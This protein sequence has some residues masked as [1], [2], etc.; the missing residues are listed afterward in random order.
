VPFLLHQ[1]LPKP[2]AATISH[3]N[4]D[5]YNALSALLR[6]GWVGQ[7]YLNPYFGDDP[8][9]TESAGVA[10]FMDRLIAPGAVTKTR[11]AAGQKLR[12][13]GRT[14][15]E[16]LWPPPGRAD[17]SLNDT[18]LVL[19]ITCDGRSLLVPGDLEE[20]GQAAL[21]AMGERVRSDVLILPH[22]GAWRD[23]LPAFVRAVA[24][25]IVLVSGSRRPAAPLSGGQAARE[26]YDKL[27]AEHRYYTTLQHGWIQVRFGRGG[28]SVRTMRR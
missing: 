2:S 4:S 24:P 9:R 8:H 26:F 20:V 1:R 11:L 3:A 10:R 22:H 15:V 27:P 6:R 7:V 21:A 5:H 19:R 25:S 17:L 12:L 28:L 18:S 23:T 14:E 13:D 16:V